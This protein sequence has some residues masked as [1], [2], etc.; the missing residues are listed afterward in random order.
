MQQLNSHNIK[1]KQKSKNSKMQGKN[2]TNTFSRL[3]SKRETLPQTSQTPKNNTKHSNN[4]KQKLQIKKLKPKSN[5]QD[6][7]FI[8][9]PLGIDYEHCKKSFTS[10]N[11]QLFNTD[12][13]NCDNHCISTHSGHI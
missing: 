8:H 6:K 9:P 13:P 1:Q 3:N 2:I 7:T 4:K 12:K 11:Y 5:K 10:N